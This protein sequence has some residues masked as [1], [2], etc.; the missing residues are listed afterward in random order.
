MKILATTLALISAT[1]AL[2]LPADAQIA[3]TER[4]EFQAGESGATVPGRIAGYEQ[5]SYLLG[6][7]AGQR[8]VVAMTS[9][10]GAANFNLYAPG[11]ST[12]LFSGSVEGRTADIVLP[13]AGDYLI[14]VFLERS[15]ARRDE[16]ADYDL[17]VAVEAPP[18]DFADGLSGGPDWWAVSGVGASDRLNIRGGPGTENAVVGR[19]AEGAA[20]R[21]LG[22]EMQGQRWCRVE[23]ADGAVRGWVAG[24]FLIEGRAP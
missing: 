10:N 9:A 15:A 24:R 8:M 1:L 4:V 19:A 5:V 22:C 21:N 13:E 20:L 7:Q 14:H 16:V 18:A 6:A 17:A 11:E 2:S 23:S 3:R 12:A